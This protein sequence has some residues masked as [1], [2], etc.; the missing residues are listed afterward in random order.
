M[1]S[2]LKSIIKKVVFSVLPL[3]L[4]LIFLEVS[5]RCLYFEE[6]G[7]SS[8][9]FALTFTFNK[10]KLKVLSKIAEMRVD[11]L[12]N[13]EALGRAFYSQ[14]GNELRTALKKEYEDNFKVLI[15]ETQAVSS[16]FAVLYMPSDDYKNSI[17]QK[18]SREFYVNLA[19]KYNVLLIDLTDKFFAYNPEITTLLPENGHLSRFGNQLVAEELSL[20]IDQNT[21]YQAGFHFQKRPKLLGPLSAN[22]ESIWLYSFS[23]P[24]RVQTNKQG[25][26]MDYDL[27]FPKQK[28]R[29]LFL[30]DSFTFGPYLPNHDIFCGLLQKKYPDKEILNGGAAGYTITDELSLFQERAK[31]T[32]PDLTVL[33]VLDNDIFGLFFLKRNEFDRKK[34]ARQPSS[35]E[36][37]FLN[38]IKNNLSEN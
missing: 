12:P 22:D 35:V 27:V 32:E 15:R 6:T 23:M 29:V 9:R 4:L 2:N 26:R 13:A 25:L 8:E 5:A 3:L 28:Q 31:Y 20:F 1:K 7:K 18:E 14:Q 10:L 36:V 16:T 30:G 17:A 19:K 37:E 33:Q 34:Q 38:K 21:N 11:G 24:Y